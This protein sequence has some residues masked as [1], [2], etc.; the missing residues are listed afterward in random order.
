MKKRVLVVDDEPRIR[1][2][3]R[4]N[5]ELEGYEV[6]EADDG[7]SAIEK[8]RDDLPDLVLLDVMMP[9][10]DG[11]E[12]LSRVR[13]FSS[14]PVIILTAKGDE[15]DLTRGLDLG[16]D[17]YITKPFSPR[18]LS[19]RIRAVLRRVEPAATQAE[20]PLVIDDGLAIDFPR[21]EVI[22]RGERIKL[23]P[24]EY[25]LLLHL[26]ENA[27]WI[28]PH[29][30]LLAKVWGPEY[31]DDNQLLRLYIT[32]LRKKIEPDPANP[33]YILTERGTGY[34]FTDFKKER[35]RG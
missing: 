15:E 23:R 34:R 26:V 1:R 9:N 17:D 33:K 14:V 4:M 30:T 24:T 16:A 10:L 21:R 18:V 25:R 7:L 2:F 13:E 22:V 35:N 12:T 11:F 27:G 32:Y 8:V 6:Y 31:R 20:E 3:V 29:E 28:L 5:L 19:S